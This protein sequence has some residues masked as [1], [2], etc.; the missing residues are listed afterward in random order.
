MDP[1]DDALMMD[2]FASFVVEMD[3]K[4]FTLYDTDVQKDGDDR[5]FHIE[6]VFI[7]GMFHVRLGLSFV[8]SG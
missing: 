7:Y 8:N 2:R 3:S 4:G 5:I 1:N 6:G